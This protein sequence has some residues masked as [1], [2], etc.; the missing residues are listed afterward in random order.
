MNIAIGSDH[1]G[2]R[3]KELIKSHL[4]TAGHVVKDF[5]TNSPEA[6]DYPLYIRP[7]AEAV[8]SG[9][10]ERGIVL[11]GSGNGEAIVANRVKGVR[12][13]L[14]WNLESAKLGRQHNNANVISIGERM[15]TE[16]MALDIVDTWLATPFE[17]GRHQ[18]R[19]DLI[20]AV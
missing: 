11:G 10:C 18:R 4:Q 7:A 19:I 2:Y 17:G 12:C 5:G 9:E 1:A 16:Q 8:A 6:V 13:A 3:Y 14:C 15:V 20:D